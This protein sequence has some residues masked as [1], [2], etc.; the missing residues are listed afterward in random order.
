ME[1][2]SS[3]AGDIETKEADMGGDLA[4]DDDEDDDEDG[5]ADPQDMMTDDEIAE[6][7]ESLQPVWLVLV[8]VI[9]V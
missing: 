8:K 5:L 3:L 1:A 4:E 2:L 9:S 7:D 6:L